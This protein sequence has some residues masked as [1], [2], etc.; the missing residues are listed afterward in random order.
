ME[1]TCNI[2]PMILDVDF[3]FQ[4]SNADLSTTENLNSGICF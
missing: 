4:Q 3:R 1:M 2:I